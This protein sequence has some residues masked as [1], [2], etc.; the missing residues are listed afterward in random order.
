MT[1]NDYLLA[2]HRSIDEAAKLME[3]AD[4]DDDVPEDERDRIWEDRHHC[5]T[6][7]V[8]TVMETVWPAIERYT[9]H[10]HTTAAA[11]D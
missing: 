4:L 11:H 5:G 9:D 2:I 7:M 1:E 8:R 10:L 3:L 6:Y